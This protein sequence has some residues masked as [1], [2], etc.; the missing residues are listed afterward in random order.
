MS[1]KTGLIVL[2]SLSLGLLVL[3]LVLPKQPSSVLEKVNK[4]MDADSLK[5]AQAIDLVNGPNPMEG[6]TIL[7]ELVSKDSTN[8]DA[9]YWLGVFAVKSQQLDKALAR[10]NTVISI[11]PNYIAAYIDRGGLYAGMQ[12][13]VKALADFRKGIEIDST[14]NFALLFSA[15]TE[16]SMGLLE[17]AKKHYEQLLR[18]NNDTIVV[19]RVNEFINRIETK[20][21]P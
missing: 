19:N 7:R 2:L 4:P 3:F 8:I 5:L 12:D 20:L 6:I 9:Q 21:N 16:E 13:T 1:K 18:H 15:Q 10:F 17:D 11:D 14:N